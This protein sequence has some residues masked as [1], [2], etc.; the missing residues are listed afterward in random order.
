MKRTSL[1]KIVNPIL[2]VLLVNQIVTG[3][4]HEFLS[5]EAYEILHGG[6]G[7]LFAVAAALH[8]IMN[9]NWVKANFLKQN[10]VPKS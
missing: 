2:G 10:A 9:W 6:S 3:L 1:L 8:V 5:H 4:L 7:L